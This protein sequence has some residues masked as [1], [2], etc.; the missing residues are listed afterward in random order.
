MQYCNDH[1]SFFSREHVETII[2][3]NK[4]LI[5]GIHSFRKKAGRED[6]LR[7]LVSRLQKNL[8]LL[9]SL[10]NQPKTPKNS[11]ANAISRPIL[12]SDYSAENKRAISQHTISNTTPS[13]ALN[14]PLLSSNN[15]QSVY[16]EASNAE[17][18][19]NDQR[20]SEQQSLQSCDNP[21]NISNPLSK[22]CFDSVAPISTEFDSQS[23]GILPKE[24]QESKW[25]NTAYYES[26]SGRTRSTAST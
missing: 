9:A 11:I 18:R 2:Q 8:F 14:S 17:F 21:G 1:N 25:V 3:E 4:Q 6:I 19:N 22:L 7:P 12:S 20:N 24:M 16:F 23:I 5:Y 10:T 13:L 15:V 26:T